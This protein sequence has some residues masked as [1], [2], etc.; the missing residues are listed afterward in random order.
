[1]IANVPPSTASRKAVASAD[2]SFAVTFEEV[3]GVPQGLSV[4]ASGSK[5]SAAMYAPRPAR[6][7]PPTTK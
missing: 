4:R 6:F 2:G 7:S 5:G 1:V 3:E